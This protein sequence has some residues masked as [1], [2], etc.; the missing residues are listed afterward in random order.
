MVRLVFKLILVISLLG[1]SDIPNRCHAQNHATHPFLESLTQEEKQWLKAHPVLRIGL[2]FDR[3]PF[4]FID[5]QGQFQGIITEYIDLIEKRLQVVFQYVKPEDGSPLSWAQ[6]LTAAQNRQL[7]CVACLLQTQQRAAYLNFTRPYLDFPYVLIVSQK[8][9]ISE[10]I[11]D[12]NGRRFAVVDTHPVSQQLR[13]QFPELIYVSVENS[14]QGM[15][16]VAR[17]KAAGFVV[18]AA[19]ASY[20]IKKHSLNQLKIAVTLDDVDTKIRMGIRKDWPLLAGI[21]DKTL[22]ALT[23]QET[24]AIHNRWVSLDYENKISRHKVL[25][26]SIPAVLIFLIILLV[27]LMVNRRLKKEVVKR[28]QT[29]KLLLKSEERLHF[30]LNAANAHHW[31]ID[32]QSR[33][34]TYSSL[35]L[36]VSAGYSEQ[37]APTTLDLIFSL[38]HP[39]DRAILDEAFERLFADETTVKIDYRLQHKPSGWMWLHSAGQVVEWD[40]QG[41]ATQIAGL[42]MDITERRNLLEKFT[43]SQERFLYSLEAADAL[44][45]QTDMQRQTYSCESYHLFI[46]CGYTEKEIPKTIKEYNALIHPDDAVLIEKKAQQCIQGEIPLIRV[47]YR[48]RRK[49]SDWAWFTS[50][51]RAVE[52]DEAGQIVKVAGI[53]MDITERLKL[54]QQIKKSQEQLRIISEHTHD[55]QSWQTLSGKL[56]WV[57]KAVEKVTGYTIDE[58]MEM[59]DY[60]FQLF[61][62]R[63][64]DIYRTLTDTVRKGKGRREAQLRVRRKDGSRV[65]VSAAYEPVLDKNGRIIGIAGAG[66]DITKQIEAEQGLRLL[67]KVFEDSLDPIV[68]TDL[69]GNIINLNEATIE[70]YGYSKQEL[71]GEHIGIFAPKEAQLRQQAFYQRCLKGE[72]LKNIEGTRVRKDGTVLPHLFTYSLLKDDKGKP[73]GVATIAKDITWIKEAEKELEEHRIHLEDIVKERTLDLEAARQVAEDATRAKSDFLANMSHEIRTPLNAIIGFAHL[74]LQTNPDARQYD[75]IQKIQN[76]SKA[77]LGVINDILDFSK[78]EAGKLDM[79]SIEFLLED[80]LETVTN[81]VGI[82]AQEKGLELIYNIDPHIPHTL[83]GDPIRLGQ[84]LLNLTNNAV[85]F[86]KH[87]E[88]VLG[89]ALGGEDAAGTLLEFSVQDTGIGL[90]RSQQ[91]KLFQAFSQADSTTTRKYGGTGL[92]LFISKSLVEMMNG[93]IRVESEHG[94]GTTFRF[95]VRLKRVGSRTITPHLTLVGK[96]TKK[97]LV[98]DDNA[99]ARAVLEKMLKAMSFEVT[100]AGSAEAGLAELETAR[101]QGAPFDLVFMDW[102]MPGMDGLQASEKIKTALEEN[103]PS[104]IMVS[105]YDREELV[106]K[107]DQLG[108]DGCLI[109]PVAPSLLSDAIMTALGRKGQPRTFGPPKEQLPDVAGIQGATLLVAEDNEVNQQ[110]AKGILESNGFVVDLADNGVL[111]L[112]AV[113]KKAYDAVLMDINMPEMDGYTAGREIRVLPG[114]K[115]LPIIA[116]TANAMTGDREK[117]LAAGMND[118]VAKP[119]DVKHL[120]NVLKKWITPVKKENTPTKTAYN[121]ASP[122]SLGP[123]PGIDI[124]A[125]LDRLAGDTNLYKNL[126]KRFAENQSDTPDKIQQALSNEDL[127]TAHILAHTIKGVSGNVSATFVF[128]SATR[129]DE[130]IKNKEIRTALALL[131]DFSARLSEVIQGIHGLETQA[132]APEQSKKAPDLETLNPQFITLERMIDENN[133][134]AIRIVSQIR[135]QISGDGMESL[136]DQLTREIDAYDFDDAQKT[137]QTLC[138]EMG[139]DRGD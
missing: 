74:A 8:N 23:P 27:V 73:L 66:K 28:Q 90:T 109:K 36:F 4:E 64:W 55:W 104:V 29:E 133:P 117:A 91:D 108:L 48:F 33:E 2:A 103:I 6:I 72:I 60:P 122:D 139:V 132:K 123:V 19:D 15:Q 34:I 43:Q 57:N 21:L 135:D 71:L 129:L 78:I 94:R 124:Q 100:Q 115:H 138:R 130:A 14:L 116:M 134:N 35:Q 126:L 68:L 70:A 49:N 9:Y 93:Q 22:A 99:N 98:V 84:I 75:Y 63:D 59:K 96:Q 137:L 39:D 54:H 83:I 81:L 30:A 26:V 128:E 62:E 61:D 24:A 87:G 58:C 47:D 86:T 136:V 37:D 102:L 12:F 106:K 105:A 101:K 51:G 92:G 111:A 97:V 50:V 17:G 46:K 32:M 127:E 118:H 107:A 120:L 119:I 89:C 42:T 110:V 125:G 112:E 13:R 67:S 121:G 38:V 45:W 10:K 88:I 76:G 77:L 20:H 56:L 16:A 40:D 85:K 82:K 5:D 41:Q 11:S 114:F 79:E 7:D 113:Q 53:T 25:T 3:P 1:L 52:W 65:W 31:Q 95:T 44:Y 18:N 69:S 131:P 80:V